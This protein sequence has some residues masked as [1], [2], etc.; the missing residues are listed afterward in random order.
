MSTEIAV[1][2]AAG[3]LPWI[4]HALK[5]YGHQVL[6]KAEDDAADAP[7]QFGLRLLHKLF[8]RKKQGEPVPDVVAKV[9]DHPGQDVYL[10]L[11][12]STITVALAESS[13][14]LAE[15]REILAKAA[16]SG[17]APVNTGPQ[18]ATADNGGIAQNI[19]AGPNAS[20]NAAHTV[21]NRNL[22]QNVHV[23]RDSYTITGDATIYRSGD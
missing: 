3:S 12:K 9:I 8:G 7:V 16:E 10:D 21:V 5:V 4:V 11:L 6:A 22:T 1:A 17:G 13:Q 23:A 14:M 19:V 2:T 15:V 20:V 18:T